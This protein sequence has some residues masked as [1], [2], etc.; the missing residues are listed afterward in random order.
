MNEVIWSAVA[1]V[2][3]GCPFCPAVIDVPIHVAISRAPDGSQSIGSDPD[4]ADLWAHS[5]THPEATQQTAG[6]TSAL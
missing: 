1:H 2:S 6:G 3:V 4:I 5:F